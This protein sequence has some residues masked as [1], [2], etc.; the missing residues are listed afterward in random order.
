M[1]CNRAIVLYKLPKVISTQKPEIC[2]LM[3]QPVS[4]RH[5]N[6]PQT[7]GTSI[8]HDINIM[9]GTEFDL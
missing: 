4:I 6:C 8:F 5:P 1:V 9:A 7:F 3:V 2:G